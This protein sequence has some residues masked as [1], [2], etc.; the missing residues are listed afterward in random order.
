MVLTCAYADVDRPE[1]TPDELGTVEQPLVIGDAGGAPP[2]PPF[3]PS[4]TVAEP[5]GRASA[6]AR[7]SLGAAGAVLGSTRMEDR[8]AGNAAPAPL[9]ALTGPGRPGV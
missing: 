6:P 7:G 8:W 9:V 2:R 1:W 5:E 3:R 4:Q